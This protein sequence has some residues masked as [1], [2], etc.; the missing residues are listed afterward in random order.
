M[1]ERGRTLVLGC[2]NLLGAD[3]G[4]GIAALDRLR[5]VALPSGVELE[6]GGTWGLNLLPLVESADRLLLLDA[7]DHGEAPGSLIV[8]EREEIPR[9]LGTKLSPH[10]ID[11]REVLALAELRG[12]LPGE[13]VVIGL[14]PERVE[15]S[16]ELSPSVAV[17]VPLLVERALQQLAAWGHDV[18]REALAGA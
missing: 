4:V 17:N 11:L 7:V 3:D 14:Q 10:Q 9:F 16:T 15:M 8:L 6:D 1:P 12:T 5:E 13:T 2:G 18:G